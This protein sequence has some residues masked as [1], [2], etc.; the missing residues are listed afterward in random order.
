MN[1]ASAKAGIAA[2]L[3]STTF[4]CRYTGRYGFI[5]SAGLPTYAFS[6]SSQPAPKYCAGLTMSI[7]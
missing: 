5:A 6:G 1:I 4:D 2:T 3:P 7:M